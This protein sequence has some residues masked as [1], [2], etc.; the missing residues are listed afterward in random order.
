MLLPPPRAPLRC[1]VPA[2]ARAPSTSARARPTRRRLGGL[3]PGV[4]SATRNNRDDRLA[5]PG[6]QASPP[7]PVLVHTPERIRGDQAIKAFSS[8]LSGGPAS[9]NPASSSATAFGR[10]P[11]VAHL[12]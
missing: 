1:P 6:S 8:L 3:Q 2:T 9:K 11:V 7:P 12:L 4:V 5:L 10:A